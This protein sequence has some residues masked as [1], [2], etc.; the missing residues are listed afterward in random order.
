MSKIKT[1]LLVLFACLMMLA[2]GLFVITACSSGGG[3]YT[4]TFM[5][6]DDEAQQ[7]EQYGNPVQTNSDDSVKLPT[8]PDKTYYRFRGWYEDTDYNTLFENADISE[9][10]TVYAR[11]SAIEVTVSYEEVNEKMTLE[12]VMEEKTSEYEEAAARQNLTFDGWYTDADFSTEYSDQDTDYLYARDMAKVTYYNGYEELWSELIVPGEKAKS[13]ANQKNSE[14][15]T[16]EESE[17]VQYYMDSEDISYAET[18]E[19]DENGKLWAK[20]SEDGGSVAFDFTKPINNNTTVTVLWKS[21]FLKYQYDKTTNTY[22]FTDIDNGLNNVNT[23][24]LA[25]YPA[26]SVLSENVTI[27]KDDIENYESTMP[28]GAGQSVKAICF[29]GTLDISNANTVIISNGIESIAGLSVSSTRSPIETIYLSASLKV[30]ENA[31][32]S[33]PNL[34]NVVIPE[35]VEVIISSFDCDLDIEVPSTVVNLS[36]VGTNLQFSNNSDFEN[37]GAGRIYQYVNG[38][39]VLIADTNIENGRLDVEEEVYGIQVGA[40]SDMIGELEYLFLPKTFKEVYYNRDVDLYVGTNGAYYPLSLMSGTSLFNG[41][42]KNNPT[43]SDAKMSVMAYSIVSILGNTNFERIA[44]KNTVMPDISDYAFVGNVKD[45]KGNYSYKSYTD[46]AF[47]NE[48]KVVLIGTKTEGTVDVIIH[49][50]DSI[51]KEDYRYEIKDG[52]KVGEKISRE[53]LLEQSGLNSIEYAAVSSITELGEDYLFD[54]SGNGLQAVNR[55]MYFTITYEYEGSGCIFAENPDE[56]GTLMVTGFDPNYKY[57]YG[58]TGRALV[59]VPNVWQGKKVTAIAPNAFSGEYRER[60]GGII[61]GSNVKTIGEGAFKDTIYL[62][63]VTIVPG[64]LEAIGRSAFEN[65]GFETIALPLANLKDVGPYAFKSKKLKSFKTAEGEE[66]YKDWPNLYE[67]TYE[68]NTKVGTKPRDYLKE[69]MFFLY[70]DQGSGIQWML[71]RYVGKSTIQMPTGPYD[72]TMMDITQYDVQ[73]IAVAGGVTKTGGSYV[74]LGSSPRYGF[75]TTINKYETSVIRFEIMEGSFYYL[76]YIAT[77]SWVQAVSFV[78]I[79]YIHEGAFTDMCEGFEDKIKVYT[80]DA[81]TYLDI[82]DVRNQDSSIFANKWWNGYDNDSEEMAFMKDVT[83]Y[84]RG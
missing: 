15:K 22:V 65:S 66:A 7:W 46:D 50:Y 20:A 39:K 54:N 31:F 82:E 5:I 74:A 43:A 76:D 27:N 29:D 32:N 41:D 68:G 59:I 63:S 37:D 51:N 10:L 24:E 71:M 2:V 9:N 16:I 33:L 25:T 18:A 61:I 3:D 70:N 69:G 47:K 72:E 81:D 40:F 58:N 48:D 30:L 4:V 83:E 26:F 45:S 38:K 35:G 23:R 36:R 34:K 60:I 62:E 12:S 8:N 49:V 53:W 42:Y 6:Y 77:D 78:N 28:T 14:G 11:F 80:K 67:Y 64:G 79:K 19:V 56:P 75:G 21:P 13:P 73:V 55:N 17:I 44:I 1:K 84:E 52:V 57:E